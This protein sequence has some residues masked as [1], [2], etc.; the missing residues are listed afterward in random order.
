M[1]DFNL[2]EIIELTDFGGRFDDFL[3]AVSLALRY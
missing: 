1:E 3:E 2:P